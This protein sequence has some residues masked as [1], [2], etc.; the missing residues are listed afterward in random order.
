MTPP[1]QIETHTTNRWTSESGVSTKAPS[2]CQTLPNPGA[3]TPYEVSVPPVE[4]VMRKMGNESPRCKWYILLL[5]SMWHIFLDEIGLQ[6]STW[7]YCVRYTCVIW[8]PV[9]L[10]AAVLS[11][12]DGDAF[13]FQ[14]PEPISGFDSHQSRAALRR[15]HSCWRKW[16]GHILNIRKNAGLI[17]RKLPFQA[18]VML[19]EIFVIHEWITLQVSKAVGKSMCPSLSRFRQ[20]WGKMGKDLSEDWRCEFYNKS[21][22]TVIDPELSTDMVFKDSSFKRKMLSF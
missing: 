1:H 14:G 6:Y 22:S 13:R 4:I 7:T 15:G 17:W 19:L 2:R 10:G 9:F 8:T 21:F 12:E 5:G 11:G 3:T 16:T 20:S 18:K